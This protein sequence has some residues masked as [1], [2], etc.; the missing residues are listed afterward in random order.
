MALA[1]AVLLIRPAY[2][3][4]DWI[5]HAVLSSYAVYSKPCVYRVFIAQGLN[6]LRGTRYDRRYGNKKDNYKW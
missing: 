4:S 6:P 3:P 5:H 2:A 1:I